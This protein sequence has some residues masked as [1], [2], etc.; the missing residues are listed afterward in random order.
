VLCHFERRITFDDEVY[1][2]PSFSVH[3][4]LYVAPVQH[5]LFA[6]GVVN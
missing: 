3:S 5:D 2:Y 4:H 1:E 6:E